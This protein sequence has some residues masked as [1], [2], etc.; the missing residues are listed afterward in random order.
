MTSL[1][2]PSEY[3]EEIPGTKPDQVLDRLKKLQAELERALNSRSMAI[4][5]AKDKEPPSPQIIIKWVDYT[6]KFGLGY[7]L[8]EGSIG[9]VLRSIPT[10]DAS[11]KTAMLPPACMLVHGAERHCVRRNDTSY[12]DR[13]QMVPMNEGIY[14]YENNGEGGLSRV[15]VAPGE[16]RVQSLSDGTAGKLNPGKD[17]YEHRKRERLVLWKKFANYMISYGREL[18]EEKAR[19]ERTMKP[20][21]ITDPTALPSDIVTFYQRFGD[22][23]CWMFCDGHMQVSFLKLEPILF[24]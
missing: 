20:P 14:F 1:F 23:S 7:I 17:V 8:S 11:G 12:P 5:S 15:R 9:C 19:E 13:M 24:R 18:E 16:F 10:A 2:S 4:L 22:V 3:Q 21:T 6:N